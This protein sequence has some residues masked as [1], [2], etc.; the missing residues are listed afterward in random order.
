V[1]HLQRLAANRA[2]SEVAQ[3]FGLGRQMSAEPT[4]LVRL[5]GKKSPCKSLQLG[6]LGFSLP[7]NG[8]VGVGVFPKGEEI[9]VGGL[10]L[11]VV[12]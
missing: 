2:V 5:A 6:V 7:Q 9:L 3:A 11:R 1:S 4:R 10:C 12:S 8:D